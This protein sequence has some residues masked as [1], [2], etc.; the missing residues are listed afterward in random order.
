MSTSPSAHAEDDTFSISATASER[1]DSNLFRLPDG[2][3]PFGSRRRS[4]TTQ[5]FGVGLQAAKTYGLQSF[6]LDATLTRDQ[7]QPYH[8]LDATG[9][10]LDAS[11]AWSLTPELTGNLSLSQIETPN[12]FSDTG[13]Q[14][15]SNLRKTDERRFDVN[16]RPGAALH[17][18]LSLLQSEDK[19]E[20]TTFER[21]NSKT[22][23]LEG[24][25][26]YEFRSGNSLE[27]YFRR[28]RGN[29]TDINADPAL[30]ADSQFNENE[31]GLGMHW[32]TS[33]R[34][35]IDGRIGYLDRHHQVFSSRNFN[36]LV[37]RANVAYNLTGKWQLQLS[38]TRTFSSIQTNVSSDSRDTTV[39]LSPVLFATDK[40]TIRPAYAIVRRSFGGAIVPV[41]NDLVMA[42]RDTTFEVDWSVY[43]SLNLSFQVAR[44]NRTS[45]DR[46][47]QF[48]D[49]SGTVSA[50]L[51]F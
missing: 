16:Y 26:V 49:H 32:I 4:A 31:T 51:R 11:W 1:Y 3:Q 33:G 50:G 46:T 25:L 19:S 2:I 18:R 6:R 41:E 20:Q 21:Q 34:S 22:T 23:S 35:T 28:G 43:R 12:N 7:Y 48:A 8:Y 30:Q 42:Q 40:I 14:T 37:G 38:A 17:P 36:G 29:Y 27:S 39:S 10:V 15:Q 9:R 24:A 13:F 45:N 5:T 44:S 47:F